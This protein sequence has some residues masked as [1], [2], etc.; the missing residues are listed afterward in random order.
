MTK[1]KRRFNWWQ[2]TLIA[3]LAVVVAFG[4]VLGSL[5]ISVS[6]FRKNYFSKIPDRVTL[7]DAKSDQ[8]LVAVGRG[9]YDANGNRVQLEGVNFGN[10]FL[11]EGWMS[12][13]SLGASYNKDG[14][15]KKVNEE[16]IVEEYEETYQEEI[17][18]A[19]R[20]NPNNFT[21]AQIEELWN[22]YYDNFIR[23]EDFVNVKSV[24]MNTI[25]LPMY[26][27]QFMQ[28]DD[29]H[30]VMKE[31]PFTRLDWFLE[32]CKKYRLYAILDLHGVAGGQS[33]FEH[34]GTR[35]VD[36]WDNEVYQEEMCTLW[37]AIATHYKTERADLA[38]TIAVYDVAN[39]PIPRTKA[40]SNSKEWNVLDKLYKA[41][42]KVDKEHIISIEG[43]W[44][45]NAFP[46]PSRYGWENVMYQIHIYNWAH[47]TISNDLF[48]WAQDLLYMT[49]AYNVPYY[50]GEFS[51][52][53]DKDAWV[54]WLDEFDARGYNWTVWNYKCVSV[55]W[56]DTTWGMYVYKMN[57]KDNKLKLDLRTA[58]FDEIYDCWSKVGTLESYTST[59]TLMEVLQTH[60]GK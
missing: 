56:W 53:N 48:Y 14:S 23:E 57:L 37:E 30:L 58:T 21:E 44:A 34:S 26:Y 45:Y 13:N 1:A 25:R 9:V 29:E 38:Q 3:V 36:F 5:C 24:G 31:N 6:A 42:R 27:R 41:I 32:M 12:V 22:V 35:D 2:R 55:G 19:L 17:D 16:G 60:F 28:G 39:E 7:T 20:N 15:F 52:Y 18:A 40:Y 8:P 59:G 43:C 4:I 50:I 11:Q 54:K 46:N 47:D 51:F 33:G 10:W 49:H